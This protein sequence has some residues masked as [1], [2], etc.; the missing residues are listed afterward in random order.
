MR[1]TV[2]SERSCADALA[3][4][5]RETIP[6][7]HRR[8]CASAIRATP[9][10][11]M[12]SMETL[13]GQLDPARAAAA[14]QAGGPFAAVALSRGST[15]C[16]T[17]RSRRSFRNALRVGQRVP[18]AARR[19]RTARRAATSSRSTRRRT[20]RRSSRSIGIEDERVLVPPKLMEL[21]RWMSRYYVTPLGRCWRASSRRR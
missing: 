6:D 4:R 19:G 10:R 20:T 2:P 17:T 21:A 1:A 16:S 15:A 7:C 12:S 9:R 11:I 5:G 8:P 3:A 14:A 18:R 13:F